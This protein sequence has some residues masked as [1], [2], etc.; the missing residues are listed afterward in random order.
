MARHQ[1]TPDI[2]TSQR[3]TNQVPFGDQDVDI[4]HKPAL[5]QGVF[6]SVAPRYDLMNDLMSLGAQ[7]WWKRVLLS[8]MQPFGHLLLD[9]AGG[10]GD[11]A[12]GF[13][14][15]GGQR[16]MVVDLTLP[17]IT[18]GRDRRYN[19]GIPDGKIL[20]VHGSVE[21]LPLPDHSVPLVSI[22]FGLRNVAD[23]TKALAEMYR[24]LTPGGRFFCMEFSHPEHPML[25][26]MER[27]YN[28]TVLPA[29]G[30]WVARDA[31]AY[32]YLAASIRRFPHQEALRDECQRAGFRQICVDNLSQGIVAIH[33]GVKI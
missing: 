13:V 3:P 32:A 27:R 11:I 1:E 26:R 2:P 19:Q 12:A 14:R 33:S 9:C 24:V 22:V 29:L 15:R 8:K 31:E 17:M 16:A 18:Q 30:R 25:A 7:R 23:R 4:Q 5:V 6:A 20:W 10:S 28:R 21:A